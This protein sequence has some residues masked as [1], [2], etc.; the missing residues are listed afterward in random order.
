V[1]TRQSGVT[2]IEL[3]TV[4]V[5]LAVLSA[6]AI[7]AY[8]NYVVRANRSDAKT[9]LLFNA[10]ALERC[11]TRYNSYV[12]NADPALGCT[13]AFPAASANGY[14]QITAPTRTASSFS[15]TATPQGGQAAD[16]GCGNL[17]LDSAN[18]RDKSGTK[19][20]SECWGK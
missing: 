19:P 11:F 15:L 14:Y 7:P 6:I 13:V 8:R 10:G 9:A 2:L 4:M 5:V 12:F 20:L 3:M 1:R 17:T 18:T 16:T